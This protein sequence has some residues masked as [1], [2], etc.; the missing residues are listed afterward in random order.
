MT[1]PQNVT[2]IDENLLYFLK[3]ILLYIGQYDA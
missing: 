3:I 2:K 1:Q